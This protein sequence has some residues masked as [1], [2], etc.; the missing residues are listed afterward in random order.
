MTFEPDGKRYRL[1]SMKNRALG[2]FLLLL[3]AI[4]ANELV[5]VPAE[6]ATTLKVV[7]VAYPKRVSPKTI[8]QVNVTVEY[9]YNVWILADIGVF[10]P[11]R[12]LMLDSLRITPSEPSVRTYTFVLE[13]PAE[14]GHW[15]LQAV[16]R[17]WCGDTWVSDPTQGS[18]S[19]TLDITSQVSLTLASG[20]SDVLFELDHSRF[21]TGKNGLVQIDVRAGAHTLTAQPTI[22]ISDAERLVFSA[23]SD[24]LR[25]NPRTLVLDRDLILAANYKTQYF[26]RVES[27]IG[28]PMGTGWYDAG[29]NATISII[30]WM[31]AEDMLSVFGRG[32]LFQGWVGGASGATPTMRILVD[33]PKIVTATW[34]ADDIFLYLSVGLGVVTV[35]LVIAGINIA[36]SGRSR[37][38]RNERRRTGVSEPRVR[39]EASNRAILIILIVAFAFISTNVAPEVSGQPETM[40]VDGAEWYYWNG[41]G[42][43]TCIIWLSGG[44]DF[45]DH[46]KIN[47]YELESFNTMRFVQDLEG[48]YCVLALKRGTDNLYQAVANRTLH[49]QSYYRRDV[50]LA[51]LHDWIRE[52]GHEYVFLAGYSIGGVIA[53]EEVVLRDP[54]RWASPN[55]V[56]IVSAPVGREVLLGSS[57]LRANLLLMYGEV[58]LPLLPESGKAFYERAPDEGWHGSY[59]Y[60]KEWRIIPGV[61]HE[62]WT[63]VDNGRYDPRAFRVMA[64]FI[65]TSKRLQLESC[66]KMIGASIVNGSLGT[67]LKADASSISILSIESPWR[68]GLADIFSVKTTISFDIHR[69]SRVFVLIYDITQLRIVGIT[70]RSVVGSGVDVVPVVL[71][72]P[73]HSQVWN[74]TA[75]VAL[76]DDA[77]KTIALQP[78]VKEFHITVSD[79]W[80]VAVQTPY[81]D[82]VAKLDD[83]EW[84]TDSEGKALFQAATGNHSVEVQSLIELGDGSR[85]VFLR[86]N[87]GSAS[88]P[89]EISVKA[90]VELVALYKHQFYL[91]VASSNGRAEGEGWHDANSTATFRISSPIVAVREDR[92]SAYL[93]QGWTGD[94]SDRSL[95]AFIQIT[96]PK[97]IVAAWVLVQD[98]ERRVPAGTLMTV[99]LSLLASVWMAVGW[100]RARARRWKGRSSRSYFNARITQNS[101]SC[102][103]N[104]GS[105]PATKHEVSVGLD[106]CVRVKQ[107]PGNVSV[108][109]MRILR[110]VDSQV[111]PVLSV[112]W[113]VFPS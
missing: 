65:E 11:S 100:I 14:E 66:E 36:T 107:D 76:W 68:S 4:I 39:R 49:T 18:Y 29:D 97:R 95:T 82:I 91:T 73:P 102:L 16:A 32:R 42:S 72:S 48:Q 83:D 92:G 74:L 106:G 109:K 62:V 80:L 98:Y 69:S 99:I 104:L 37:R 55:G 96:G 57:N 20:R 17:C 19:F 87:D 64:N 59:W 41:V 22:Q 26:V 6:R 52:Q 47:P 103:R 24:G 25:S 93:F 89:R 35:G 13:A 101:P 44:L 94:T 86:W 63:R 10:D 21:T 79:K 78:P 60:H 31:P 71:L 58:G 40:S 111:F 5:L 108:N 50:F 81:S 70:A 56:V 61:E 1:V 28:R 2:L 90:D 51:K 27:A 9:S 15:N 113:E 112:L 88:N 45:P 33:G 77:S 38:P 84:R 23:W 67:G 110:P 7:S 8:F 75:I 34:R 105:V 54:S 43:D 30:P 53:L 12:L 3:T 46:Q 85:A